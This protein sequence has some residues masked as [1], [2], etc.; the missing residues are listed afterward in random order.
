MQSEGMGIVRKSQDVVMGFAVCVSPR[1]GAAADGVV[2]RKTPGVAVPP[3][4]S[5]RTDGAVQERNRW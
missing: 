4:R 3:H 5:E 1:S 2:S